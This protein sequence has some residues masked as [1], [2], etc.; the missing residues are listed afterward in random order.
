MD[1][2]ANVLNFPNTSKQLATIRIRVGH[3]SDSVP[4]AKVQSDAKREY[5]SEHEKLH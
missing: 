1:A 5:E 2:G 3:S 4:P